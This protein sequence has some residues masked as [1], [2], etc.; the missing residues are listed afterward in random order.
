MLYMQQEIITKNNLTTKPF[1]HEVIVVINDTHEPVITFRGKERTHKTT[2][3]K[4]PLDTVH[5]RSCFYSFIFIIVLFFVTKCPFL[6]LWVHL[7]G[8]SWCLWKHWRHETKQYTH[9]RTHTQGEVAVTRGRKEGWIRR[10]KEMLWK[11]KEKKA[12]SIWFK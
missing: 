7:E 10:N 9:A 8:L 4:S 5:T 11:R 12:G 1:N 3:R 6:G 2:W